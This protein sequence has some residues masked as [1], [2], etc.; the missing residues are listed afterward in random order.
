VIPNKVFQI[1]LAGKL[2]VTR[3]SGAIRELV[4]PTDEGIILIPPGDPE[5]LSEAVLRIHK[6]PEQWKYP[7]HGHIAEKIVPISLGKELLAILES[8]CRSKNSD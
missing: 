1:I 2:L 5:A 4:S 6:S 8:V 7:L 3:D